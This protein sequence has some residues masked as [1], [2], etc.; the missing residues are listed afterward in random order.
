MRTG[1]ITF[2]D[3]PEPI[4][5]FVRR[6]PAE[7][8]LCAFNLG[9]QSESIGLD[10]GRDVIPLRGHGLAGCL[11]GYQLDLPAYGAVFAVLR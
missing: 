2:L 4:L 8:L 1:E 3:A 5:V 11:Q 6:T 7:R 10:L 9:G